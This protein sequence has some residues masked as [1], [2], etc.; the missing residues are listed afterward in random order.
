MAFVARTFGAPVV[1]AAILTATVFESA[2]RPAITAIPMVV[3]ARVVAAVR[4]STLR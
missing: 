3:M 4:I 1:V 2:L